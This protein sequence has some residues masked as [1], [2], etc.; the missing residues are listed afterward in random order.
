MDQFDKRLLSAHIN[1]LTYMQEIHSTFVISTWILWVSL[2]LCLS[3]DFGWFAL[4]MFESKLLYVQIIYTFFIVQSQTNKLCVIQSKYCDQNIHDSTLQSSQSSLVLESFLGYR[5][6]ELELSIVKLCVIDEA[7][8]HSFPLFFCFELSGNGSRKVGRLSLLL[9]NPKQLPGWL[10]RQ[11]EESEQFGSLMSTERRDHN[12]HLGSH[13]ND[14]NLLQTWW[15]THFEFRVKDFIQNYRCTKSHFE[16]PM[17]AEHQC[18]SH[19]RV[20]LMFTV[21]KNLILGYKFLFQHCS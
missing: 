16:Q 1:G 8:P 7:I 14:S 9:F 20:S 12:R 21:A 17:V 15:H 10:A 4:D 3:K 19:S 5:L 18:N 6:L 11:R 13:P 2:N